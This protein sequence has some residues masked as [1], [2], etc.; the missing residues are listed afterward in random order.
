MKN[1]V[2]ITMLSVALVKNGEA[3]TGTNRNNYS[4]PLENFSWE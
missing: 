1:L 3:K 4:Q 2:G